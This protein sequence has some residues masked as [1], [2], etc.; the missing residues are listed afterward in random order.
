MTV[1]LMRATQRGAIVALN[2]ATPPAP[3]LEHVPQGTEPPYIRFGDITA[4]PIGSKS[5]PA[6]LVSFELHSVTRGTSRTQLF[7][8][9]DFVET[10]LGGAELID[11]GTNFQP[12][13]IE[14][15]SASGAGPDGV[16]Y[17]GLSTFSVFAEPA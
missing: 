6:R 5:D 3:V 8:L 15:S 7:E 13:I 4:E 10:V 16:T 9:M 14:T 2:A 1:Q 17:V 11:A 12:T